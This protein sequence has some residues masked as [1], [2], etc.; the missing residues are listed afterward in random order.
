[1][2]TFDWLW[3]GIPGLALLYIK[4][5]MAPGQSRQ[6]VRGLKLVT[7]RALNAELHGWQRFIFVI[8]GLNLG[9]VTI[10]PGLQNRHF[11][12]A[13]SPGTGKTTLDRV[14][15]DQ[16]QEM[17]LPAIVVDPE[18]EFVQEYYN[19]ARGDFILN[20]LDQR[21]PFWSPWSEFRPGHEEMDIAAFAQSMKRGRPALDSKQEFFQRGGQVLIATMLEKT[22]SIEQ[23][24]EFIKLPLP[25]IVA[26]LKNTLAYQL[27][28]TNGQSQAQAILGTAVT[29]LIDHLQYVPKEHETSRRWCAREY[30]L[31]PKGAW[32]FLSSTEDS[33]SAAKGIQGVWMDILMR[34]LLTRPINHREKIWVMADEIATLGYQGQLEECVTRGRK[35]EI[36]CVLTFQDSAQLRSIYGRDGAESLLSKPNTTVIF[37]NNCA[38]TAAWGARQIGKKEVKDSKTGHITDSY[39]VTDSQIQAL[40]QLRA[41]VSIAGHNRAQI[42][43]PPRFLQPKVEPFIPRVKVPSVEIV[44]EPAPWKAHGKY[45]QIW[46]GMKD[47]CFNPK[48]A[49]WETYGGRG[50]TMDPRWVNDYELF[51]FEIDEKFPSGRP[52]LDHSLDRK[53]NDQG[54]ILDNIWRWATKREQAEN[55]R[56]SKKRAVPNQEEL[57]E[58]VEENN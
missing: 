43:I 21:C 27:V 36:C 19:E 13:G 26:R 58:D 24:M 8:T 51:E 23:L 20:P 32:L 44:E 41:Y 53:D 14:I 15:L 54:Y 11:I 52:S 22:S 16:I 33:Q 37:G 30:A 49:N 39:L 50:I 47:R 3:I 35:R 5:F 42:S 31:D 7:P 57:F 25:A 45:R 4:I 6:F 46:A 28:S 34:W 56:N 38:E 18:S 10:P 17:G 1:M 12:I 40:P 29:T 48:N 2:T 55:R 9:G